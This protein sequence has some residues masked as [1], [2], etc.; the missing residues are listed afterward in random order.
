MHHAPVVV[1]RVF[2]SGGR[3]VTLRTGS[4]E[5]SLG[6]ARSDED[7]IEFLRLAGLPD[8]DEAVFGDTALVEWDSD[9]P[10]VYAADPPT[11]DLP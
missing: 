4:G 8:P 5:Q 9:A 2:P 11:D 6:L 7:V 10:H 1:H 3:R